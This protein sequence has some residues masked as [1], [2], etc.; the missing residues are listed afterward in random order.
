M[1]S[2]LLD[3][4]VSQSGSLMP[5]G[6]PEELGVPRPRELAPLR[7]G[8]SVI[9]LGRVACCGGSV[10]VNTRSLIGRASVSDAALGHRKSMVWPGS[11]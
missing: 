4:Y 1:T 9:A 6:K 10:L 3:M 2:D 7:C 11:L 8:A 5:R